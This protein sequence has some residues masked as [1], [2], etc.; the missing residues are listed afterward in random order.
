MENLKYLKDVMDLEKVIDGLE[1]ATDEE[2]KRI[3]FLNKQLSN[4]T[5]SIDQLNLQLTETKASLNSLEKELFD[6]DKKLEQARQNLNSVTSG[7]QEEA[8][9]KTINLLEE[10]SNLKQ[11][12]ILELLEK[13]EEIE[14]TVSE[15]QEFVKG[16]NETISEINEE[17]AQIK[18]NND[19][20]IDNLNTQIDGLLDEVGAHVK[21][22]YLKAKVKNHHTAATFLQGNSCGSCRLTYSAGECAEFN[23]GK[24]LILCRGCGRLILPSTLRKL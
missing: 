19:T 7:Q 12:T 17:V 20:K 23:N 4:K 24:D 8:I 18:S 9:Q 6:T 16:I 10:D 13:V 11:D 14:A 22:L 15:A 5:E 1:N 2:L 3:D 21:A